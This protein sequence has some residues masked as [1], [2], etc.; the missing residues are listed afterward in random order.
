MAY[1]EIT[2][3][4]LTLILYFY[5]WGISYFFNRI[6][7][8]F[9]K[10]ETVYIEYH[11]LSNSFSLEFFRQVLFCWIIYYLCLRPKWHFQVWAISITVHFLSMSAGAGNTHVLYCRVLLLFT[12]LCENYLRSDSF[13][14]FQHAQMSFL[15]K[16]SLMLT[17]FLQK[18]IYPCNVPEDGQWL[19]P[20][21]LV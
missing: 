11:W 7:L 10:H 6:M 5:S 2:S 9:A 12:R 20:N 1:S 13:S 4:A 19:F 18:T 17:G 3:P 16:V 8:T 14:S 21:L 15:G